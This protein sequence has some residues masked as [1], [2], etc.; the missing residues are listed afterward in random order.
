MNGGRS[1]LVHGAA[2]RS[3]G[4]RAIAPLALAAVMVGTLLGAAVPAVAAPLPTDPD[5]GHHEHSAPDM[6]QS[7]VRT[8]SPRAFQRI[9]GLE[10]VFGLTERP[11]DAI[12]TVG[13][14]RADSE[15]TSTT[16]ND[17]GSYTT[18]VSLDALNWQDEAGAWRPFDDTIAEADASLI[19]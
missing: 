3:S 8:G 12:L 16:R 4:R 14:T 17:D 1:G 19:D 6:S 9:R 15:F 11:D 13:E 2:S 18:T 5:A 7:E 10:H